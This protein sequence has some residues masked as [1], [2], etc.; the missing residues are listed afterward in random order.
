MSIVFSTQGWLTI[1]QLT[2]AWAR[3]LAKGIGEDP[4]QWEEDL[5]HVLLEDIVNGR[6]DEAGPPRDGHRLGVARITLD[7][8]PG[9]IEGH[10]FARTGVTR[11][12]LHD[13]VVMKEAAL[14]FARRPQL[15]V[16]TWW[17][18]DADGASDATG[19][20]AVN[21]ASA[22]AAPAAEARPRGRRPWKRDNVVQAIRNDLEQ[23][24][25]TPKGLAV[26]L[27]KN[28]AGEYAVSRD[29]ARKARAFV[30]SELSPPAGPDKNDGRTTPGSVSPSS[31]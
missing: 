28:L 18:G 12:E 7:H 1:A 20:S 22:P 30:L 16:P 9:F 15:P 17:T 3:E 14:D 6:L 2:R 11:G 31:T 25:L 19:K 4:R 10:W 5:T 26:M 23:G 8:K 27:E 13:I 24:R 29:T 21:P